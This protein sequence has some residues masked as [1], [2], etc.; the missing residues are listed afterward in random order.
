VPVP[1]FMS[2]T[3]NDLYSSTTYTVTGNQKELIPCNNQQY[4]PK[5]GVSPSTVAITQESYPRA[6]NPLY[7]HVMHDT[8]TAPT[9]TSTVDIHSR[10]PNSCKT[11]PSV[12]TNESQST[13]HQGM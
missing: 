12:H 4:G 1:M 8:A 7:G 10:R 11:P 5:K 13:I 2:L 3:N 9:I 6:A